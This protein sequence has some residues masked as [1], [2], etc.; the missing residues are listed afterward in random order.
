MYD[1]VYGLRARSIVPVALT[2]VKLYT[3]DWVYTASKKILLS[4]VC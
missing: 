3:V 2:E 1:A 4:S